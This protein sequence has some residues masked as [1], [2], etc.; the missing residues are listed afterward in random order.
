MARMLPR[1]LLAA[2]LALTAI[3]EAHATSIAEI[4]Q[5]QMT[6]AATY[7]V[8]GR[9]VDVWT[10][11][12]ERGYL[13]TRAGVEVSHTWKGPDSPD[14]LVVESMGGTLG[15][16]RMVV[17]ASARFSEGEEAILFLTEIDFGRKLTPVGMFLGKF[18]IRRAPGETRA[19]VMTWTTDDAKYDGQYLPHPSAER[20][21]YLDDLVEGIEAHLAI[22][23]DGNPIP[24]LT[25]DKLRAINTPERRSAR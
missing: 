15:E 7:I 23:W 2:A 10:E 20:R 6:D 21:V 9:I 4:T 22:G 11:V 8:R 13:W 5:D 14:Y 19:H 3:P 12:D 25:E 17:P 18:N 16:R 1:M 24:G